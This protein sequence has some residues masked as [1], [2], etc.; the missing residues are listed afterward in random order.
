MAKLRADKRNYKKAFYLSRLRR[1]EEAFFHF[2]E[3]AKQAFKESNYLMY[4]FA[5]SNFNL[6]ENKQKLSEV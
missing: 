1:Y 5:E 4:Y 6:S 3:V 2:S